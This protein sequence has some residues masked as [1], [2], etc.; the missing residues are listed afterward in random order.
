MYRIEFRYSLR[1]LTQFQG[2]QTQIYT[3][4]KTGKIM[5]AQA[6][7]VSI[8]DTEHSREAPNDISRDHQSKKASLQSPQ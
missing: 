4:T 3:G 7:F 8:K 5:K 6:H 1:R 2:F